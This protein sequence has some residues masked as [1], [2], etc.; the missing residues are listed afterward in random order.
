MSAANQPA[1]SNVSVPQD[2]GPISNTE[3]TLKT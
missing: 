3:P 1:T 2:N